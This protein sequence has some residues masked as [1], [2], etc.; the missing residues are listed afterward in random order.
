LI[1]QHPRGEVVAMVAPPSAQQDA[2]KRMSTEAPWDKQETCYV[3]LLKV[4][5]NIVDKPGE[6]KFRH[7][8]TEN[9]ALQN[10]IFSVPG[11]MD[12]LLAIGFKQVGSALDM[13]EG[14]A[15]SVAQAR[16]QL[17]KFAN[18][19]NMN[20]LRR[21]RDL[22]I[23]EEKAKAEEKHVFSCHKEIGGTEEE[24]AA[25]KEQ[26]ERDRKEFEAERAAMG[27]TQ[28][29]KAKDFNF[30]ANEADTSFLHK[31]KGG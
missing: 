4:L 1:V 5:A 17:E 6:A 19:A 30:G 29:S 9:A 7:L 24:K 26:L 28:D 22:K 31:N 3:T 13:D 12:Y 8:N 2:L 27:P 20:E 21:K 16:T 25:I 10:K 11:A 15:A 14:N 23:V 18:E